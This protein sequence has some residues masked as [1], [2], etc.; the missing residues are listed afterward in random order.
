MGLF[1]YL[2]ERRAQDEARRA[3]DKSM[4]YFENLPEYDYIA[5]QNPELEGLPEDLQAQLIAEDPTLKATQMAALQEMQNL[6]KEGMSSEDAYNYM[7]AASRTGQEARGREEAIINEMQRKGQGGSGME[8]ALRTQAGQ[9][10]VDRFAENQALQAAKTAEMQALANTQ[11][12]AMAGDIRGQ[13]FKTNATNTDILNQFA[14]SNAKNRQATQGRNID[15]RNLFSQGETGEQRRVQSGNV[16]L[17][18][19]RARDMANIRTNQAAANT[20]KTRAGGQVGDQLAGGV[21][22]GVGAAYDYFTKP[23]DLAK[24]TV[25]NIF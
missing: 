3:A 14:Q 1:G 25:G 24:K 6:A 20:A 17:A 11:Q 18:G 21:M 10:A 8:Y 16:D 15:R 2:A 9:S 23:D 7:T 4:G 5:G 22:Q 19:Q 12:A 13:D